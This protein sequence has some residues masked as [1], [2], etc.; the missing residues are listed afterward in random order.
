M[1]VLHVAH[2]ALPHVGGIETYVHRTARDLRASGIES[3]VVSSAASAGGPGQREIGGVPMTYLSSRNLLP[4]NP[5]LFGLK[6]YLSSKHPDV[7]HVHSIWFL[8]SLQVVLLKRVLG[9]RV[10]NSVHG[11]WPDDSNFAVSIF[12][13]VFRPVAQFVLNRSDIVI[14]YNE[15]ERKRLLSRFQVEPARIE[16]VAMGFDRIVPQQSM[17]TALRER[18]GRFVLFTGRI[19]PDKNAHALAEAVARIPGLRAVFLGPADSDYRQRLINCAPDR[20]VVEPPLDSVSQSQELAAYYAAAEL[21][22]VIGS[23]EG[24]PT[25]ILESLAQGTPVLAFAAGGSG[26]VIR[27]GDNGLLISSLDDR[28]VEEGIQRYLN[29]TDDQRCA[30][31]ER[32]LLSAEPYLWSR[33]FEQIRAALDRAVKDH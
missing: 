8:P 15:T 13:R 17:V 9:Y 23:W 5:A 1:K 12:V 7:V 10:V 18:F 14:V 11:V 25:R 33:K 26:E 28:A 16:M 4:R 19:I 29:M 31:R 20:I 6:R 24:L 22:V 30:M 27:D 21:S 32:A 3:E 2:Y